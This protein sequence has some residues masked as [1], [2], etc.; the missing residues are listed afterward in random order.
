MV[1]PM[2]TYRKAP[3]CRSLSMY[4]DTASTPGAVPVASRSCPLLVS[5]PTRIFYTHN[6][7]R[8]MIAS[9]M[10]TSRSDSSTR[11]GMIPIRTLR[12]ARTSSGQWGFKKHW[13]SAR[14][15]TGDIYQDDIQESQR[16]AWE[17]K[18]EDAG[19]YLRYLKSISSEWPQLRLLADFMEVG[20]DPLRWRNFYGDDK[21]NTYTYPDN[22]NDREARR[23][24]RARQTHVAQLE[25]HSDGSV[26]FLGNYRTPEQLG[27]ALEELSKPKEGKEPAGTHVQ[28]KLF[29]VEDLSREVIE[30]LGHRFDIDPDFFRSHIYDYAWYNIRDPY[31]DPPDLHMNVIRK[32]WCQIRFCR[33]RYFASQALFNQ[34]QDA[35]NKFN[36]GRKLYEDENKAYWDTDI[37]Q[38]L[39]SAWQLRISGLIECVN[40]W[41]VFFSKLIGKSKPLDMEALPGESW[42]PIPESNGSTDA[43][44]KDHDE[45]MINGKI[46]LMRTRATLWRKKCEE[47]ECE[48]G[49]LLLDP[50]IKEG[51]SLW[52]GYRNWDPMPSA[53]LAVVKL[54]SCVPTLTRGK[55]N[56]Q[57]E[58]SF[59]ED[60]MYWAQ[61]PDVFSK[62]T[63][64]RTPTPTPDVH[65]TP[66][67]ALL[68][69]VCADW[70]TLS[71][72]IKTRLSQVDWE[73]THPKEF[74]TQNQ[75][76]TILRKLHTWR[77][78][79]PLYREMLTETKLRMFHTDSAGF[80]TSNQSD[81]YNSEFGIVLAQMEEYEERIDR[82][83]AVVMSSISILD[84]RR[85]E[86]LTLLATLFVPLSLVGT[87]F[88]MSDDI[89]EIGATFGYWAAASL[90]LLGVL[91]LWN[92]QTRWHG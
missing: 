82:L 65:Y 57:T 70:L 33:A 19:P 34:G 89:A 55:S 39:G 22:P 24:D 51:F 56:S 8:G 75:I 15:H 11:L 74:L 12:R 50:T 20:T 92:S 18:A 91:F 49:V 44:I 83:T 88:S 41:L 61:R 58:A 21:N 84:S 81:A 85:T 35:A 69:L 29:V 64:K 16:K 40:D 62:Q 1:W 76:D 53:R 5:P 10:A 17:I 42:K 23:L 63:L 3:Q 31:W 32:D 25:Y 28:L 47:D 30:R 45:Q 46:G 59:F 48:I 77:R 78:L 67:L 43:N 80:M 27:D 60:F 9:G 68:S 66:V 13:R 2:L 4:R 6:H 38:K 52:R 37:P 87:L 7:F 73:I 90:F 71:E 79:V 14:Y 26:K 54:D 36:I 86:H 72:Y